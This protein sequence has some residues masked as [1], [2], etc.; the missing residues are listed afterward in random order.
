VT[1]GHHTRL[2]GTCGCVLAG[3]EST[4]GGM[5]NARTSELVLICGGCLELFPHICSIELTIGGGGLGK[6]PRFEL[7]FPVCSSHLF[8]GS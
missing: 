6:M 5:V 3:F 7:Y 1:A 8:H 4:D 2:F